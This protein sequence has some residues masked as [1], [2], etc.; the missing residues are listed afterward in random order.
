M[1]NSA[2]I[3][4][5]ITLIAIYCF[6]IR[7][8]TNL[9][10]N[11]GYGH[12]TAEQKQYLASISNSLFCHNSPSESSVGNFNDLPVPDLKNR[13][14]EPGSITKPIEQ[15]FKAKFT[16]YCNLSINFLIHHRKSD[17]IFPFDYF[18]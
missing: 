17:L 7:T 8:G 6:A 13:S 3:L 11:S 9:P 12:Q 16:Q 15:L 18:W 14:E 5:V 4:G 1:Q 2:R 10:T